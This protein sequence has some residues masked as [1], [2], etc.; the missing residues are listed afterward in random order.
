MSRVNINQLVKKIPQTLGE[1]CDLSAKDTEMAD[2]MLTAGV[3]PMLLTALRSEFP[4]VIQKGA[5]LVKNLARY[6]PT[7][8]V[9]DSRA[10]AVYS[11]GVVPLLV[12]LLSHK[13]AAVLV[14]AAMALSNM[15]LKN[16]VRSDTIVAMGA[17]PKL[18][19]M[20]ENSSRDEVQSAAAV[21]V[22]SICTGTDDSRIST[23]ASLLLKNE[24]VPKLSRL[25]SSRSAETRNSAVR[26]LRSITYVEGGKDR[27]GPDLV[28]LFLNA[29]GKIVSNNSDSEVAFK[30]E[31][32]SSLIA[33]ME[34][35]PSCIMAFTNH[36]GVSM[37]LKII[38]TKHISPNLITACTSILR[39]SATNRAA[40]EE[41]TRQQKIFIKLFPMLMHADETVREEVLRLI[42][43]LAEIDDGLKTFLI[44]VGTVP[45]AAQ[46]LILPGIRESLMTLALDL[47]DHL[48][49]PRLHMHTADQLGY[50]VLSTPV[51]P[52]LM[53]QLSSASA[54]PEQRKLACYVVRNLC[55]VGDAEVRSAF[56]QADICAVMLGFLNRPEDE[57]ELYLPSLE[58]L[59]YLCEP[60]PEES[61]VDMDNTRSLIVKDLVPLLP[62]LL[63]NSICSA[64][65]AW[66]MENIAK[67]S[68][69]HAEIFASSGIVPLIL[70]LLG[71]DDEA[72]VHAILGALIALTLDNS[73]RRTL[74][75][76]MGGAPKVAVLLA[77]P[78]KRCRIRAAESLV[79]LCNGG[80]HSAKLRQRLLEKGIIPN[81]A[82]PLTLAEDEF[83]PHVA[84]FFWVLIRDGGEYQKAAVAAGAIPLLTRFLSVPNDVANW[85]AAKALASLLE[86]Y[87]CLY[88]VVAA[89]AVPLI[90]LL[91]DS[92]NA[93]CQ[94]AAIEC[95]CRLSFSNHIEAAEEAGVVPRLISLLGSSLLDTRVDVMIALA[96]IRG[97][98]NANIINNA[99]LSVMHSAEDPV[100][101]R[102]AAEKLLSAEQLQTNLMYSATRKLVY[103][104]QSDPDE[105]RMVV[106]AI[107]QSIDSSSKADAYVEAGLIPLLPIL[108]KS[109]D[110][111]VRI[112]T[113][114]VI[115]NLVVESEDR[116]RAVAAAGV[117]PALMAMLSSTDLQSQLAALFTIP[118]LIY[119]GIDITT[120]LGDPLVVGK[121]VSLLTSSTI[122]EVLIG[123]CQ[124]VQY[125]AHNNQARKQM[126]EHHCSAALIKLFSSE[127]VQVVCEA[128]LALAA[129]ASSTAGPIA[130]GNSNGAAGKMAASK[131][132]LFS[133]LST[134]AASSSSST[135]LIADKE[136]AKAIV[137]EG[138]VPALVKALKSRRGSKVTSTTAFAL[139]ALTENSNE[140]GNAAVDSGALSVLDSMMDSQSFGMQE[141]G[142]DV[143]G[144]LLQNKDAEQRARALRARSSINKVI[145]LLQSSSN[146]VR[147]VAALTMWHASRTEAGAISLLN[148]FTS[149]MDLFSK[150]INDNAV[151][152]SFLQSFANLTRYADTDV[153]ET[154]RSC[155]Q[156]VLRM[157][158]SLL[159]DPKRASALA[160]DLELAIDCFTVVANLA[161]SPPSSGTQTVVEANPK[162]PLPGTTFVKDH[163]NILQDLLQRTI[164]K[165]TKEDDFLGWAIGQPV[166][167]LSYLD[168]NKEIML[169]QGIVPLLVQLFTVSSERVH[170]VVLKTLANISFA[171]DV[172]DK[173]PELTD[174]LSGIS[175]PHAALSLAAIIKHNC[176]GRVA[177]PRMSMALADAISHRVLLTGLEGQYSFGR[178]LRD[179]LQQM[180]Y[181][182]LVPDLKALTPA[183]LQ[184]LHTAI[185]QAGSVVVCVDEAIL[186][187]EAHHMFLNM[188]QALRR[189]IIPIKTNASFNLDG[190]GTNCI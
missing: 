91:L 73:P 54:S 169:V 112:W 145:S 153:R 117:G 38:T 130:N 62:E 12:D 111:F 133:G 176:S 15:A 14:Q 76:D 161:P 70:D 119:N 180:G 177:M 46:L 103:L 173:A 167:Q 20:C 139:S 63:V 77:S 165:C 183:G 90:V 66:L 13:S 94:R 56:L 47:L 26:A 48:T 123:A 83:L 149:F 131:S 41:V 4:D 9:D 18:L 45:S 42:V 11:S 25:L 27:Y 168:E 187:S 95:I 166:L 96:S 154:M 104:L 21:T 146:E 155:G 179:R 129:L 82:A 114:I 122:D 151:T 190:Y 164:S 3:M 141:L 185:E 8:D 174:L 60:L 72:V 186:Q 163:I 30:I 7:T 58:T 109:T 136:A 113:S 182:V 31:L 152:L 10:D 40:I 150:H 79:L 100:V 147:Q 172:F 116:S 101:V 105:C 6:D 171:G 78:S 189:T 33:F 128:A 36:G 50:L 22:A 115:R 86:D 175:A 106:R 53:H 59:G 2:S 127:T 75:Y 17:V 140:A 144:T 118:S 156:D 142:A 184:G 65:C 69:P 102:V 97:P 143:L 120:V 162:A 61:E 44:D 138:A 134:G 89:G 148:A 24:A 107:A 57:A 81:L 188:C 23:R 74:V 126:I 121:I 98:S 137:D 29:L 1:L 124:T 16:D 132:N 51:I 93:D 158:I 99:F 49:T 64:A 28:T 55:C 84:L 159:K 181:Q 19:G 157:A 52:A 67:Y 37:I 35:S 108:L 39:S 92:E 32:I 110:S 87:S 170:M 71:A 178:W 68:E 5:Q 85:R 160:N 125:L 80:D 43:G 34:N 135:G 88:G